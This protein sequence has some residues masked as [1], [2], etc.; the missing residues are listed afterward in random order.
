MKFLIVSGNPKDDGL[1][2]GAMQ[3]VIRGASDGGA[4]VEILNVD[5]I[6]RCRVCGEG[7]GVCRSEH[8]CAFSDDGFDWAQSSVDMSDMICFITPVY[9]GEAAE[10]LKA[11]IDRFRRCEHG[12][13]GGLSGKPMLLVASPGGSGNGLLSC[14]EQLDRFCRHT[15]AK[16]FDYIGINRW[17]SDYKK[18]SAYY[19]A[20]AMAEG[21][22]PGDTI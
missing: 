15:G 22:L 6:G 8:R 2:H 21:R 3:E 16:I 13:E 12:Q 1:C 11:F 17:N 20:R 9:W 19:A 10:G 14:L 5:K 4:S 18:V 7:W